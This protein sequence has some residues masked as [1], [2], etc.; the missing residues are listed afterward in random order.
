MVYQIIFKPS[1]KKELNNLP[2][3]D[4]Y[5]I[6]AV[7]PNLAVNPFIGKK[8]MGKEAGRYSVRV[9]PYRVVYEV[10]KHI[11]TVVIVRIGHR[12]GVYK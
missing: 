3:A 8:L 10:Y 2:Q 6:L 1:A 7:I 4:Q 9:W 11:I 5:R 12:Q